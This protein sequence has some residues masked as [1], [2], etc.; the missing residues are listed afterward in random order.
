MELAEEAASVAEAAVAAASVEG[1]AGIAVDSL[2]GEVHMFADTEVLRLAGAGEGEVRSLVVE[3]ILLVAHRTVHTEVPYNSLHYYFYCP[4]LVE[5]AA[6]DMQIVVG[7]AAF[8]VDREGF[9][10]FVVGTQ[11]CFPVELK[12]ELESLTFHLTNCQLLQ[13]TLQMGSDWVEGQL[14]AQLKEPQLSM[15]RVLDSDC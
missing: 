12:E 6:V 13:L 9:D 7:R 5:A 11:S 1:F 8:V 4:T 10:S 14:L 3:G 2:A 15:A